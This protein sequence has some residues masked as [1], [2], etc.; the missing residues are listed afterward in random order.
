MS[1]PSGA[2]TASQGASVATGFTDEP[3][4]VVGAPASEEEEQHHEPTVDTGTVAGA[5]E[6]VA[7]PKGALLTIFFWFW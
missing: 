6:S 5:T 1:G 2:L 3:R 4:T 7:V